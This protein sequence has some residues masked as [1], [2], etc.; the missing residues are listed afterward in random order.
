[1]ECVRAHKIAKS[2][3]GR[4]RRSTYVAVKSM[5]ANT[6]LGDIAFLS[7]VSRACESGVKAEAKALGR[8]N[9]P[10]G[11]A[12]QHK[13]QQIL[14]SP[15]ELTPAMLVK[16]GSRS[17]KDDLKLTKKYRML[18]KHCRTEGVRVRVLVM[19]PG[20]QRH[21]DNTSRF[22]ERTGVLT[23]TLEWVV[24]S[25]DA[26]G[27]V[28]QS[29]V[30]D[31]S[32][33]AD[34]A[35]AVG[36]VKNQHTHTHTHTHTQT[37]DEKRVL[38]EQLST[39]E[40]PSTLYM[41][42]YN[43]PANAARVYAVSSSSTIRESLRGLTLIEF[44]TILVDPP[45]GSYTVIDKP[46]VE[47]EVDVVAPPETTATAA[48]VVDHSKNGSKRKHSSSSS[49]SSSSSVKRQKPT[50]Q[51]GSVPMRPTTALP[52][53]VLVPMPPT[54]MRA[55][56][57]LFSNPSALSHTHVGPPPSLPTAPRYGQ[58]PLL[59]QPPT[60]HALTLPQPPPQAPLDQP[61]QS[62]KEYG[63]QLSGKSGPYGKFL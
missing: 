57:V 24:R 14:T 26:A 54:H 18:T 41:R 13:S 56:P 29:R 50:H 46:I 45:A 15:D 36:R 43:C 61:P 1:V 21:K 49:P 42:E 16:G 11:A 32:T 55:P 23:W 9:L 53:P 37:D 58:P 34:A 17:A 63:A 31:T 44:P 6:L 3:D 52:P 39:A 47:V 51:P 8:R 10:T 7:D 35:K 40:L 22:D 4:P 33:W 5:T 62:L 2:C 30:A 59:H 27:S 25:G 28:L 38:E 60:S 19:P 48:A 20:M 12:R